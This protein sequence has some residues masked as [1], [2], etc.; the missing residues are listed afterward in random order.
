MSGDLR[1]HG[2]QVGGGIGGVTGLPRTEEVPWW[3]IGM[4]FYQLVRGSWTL[5]YSQSWCCG[6]KTEILGHRKIVLENL[7]TFLRTSINQHM[8][9]K[10]SQT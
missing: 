8:L 5:L 7:M 6:K 10:F 2:G 9:S 3:G 4:A 1:L